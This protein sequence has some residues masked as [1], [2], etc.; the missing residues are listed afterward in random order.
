MEYKTKATVLIPTHN[1]GELIKFA[2]NSVLKQ[3]L[4]D[5][6]LIIIGDGAPEVTINI[7][8][9]YAAKDQR[10]QYFLFPKGERN[11]ELYRHQILQQYSRGEIVCYLSDDDIWLTTHLETMYAAL[12]EADMANTL[13]VK[14]D[15][16]GNLIAGVIDLAMPHYRK[17][18]LSTTEWGRF[19]LSNFAHRLDSY[20]KLPYGWRTTPK[21]IPTDLYMYQQFLNCKWV[22]AL[23]VKKITALHPPSSLRLH[24]S[25][26]ERI[27]ELSYWNDILD[28]TPVNNLFHDQVFVACIE[29]I[30][31][32]ERLFL[33]KPVRIIITTYRFMQKLMTIVQKNL[34]TYGDSA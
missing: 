3:T 5:F 27:N 4:Q 12:K 17:K 31:H 26:R 25:Q 10:I 30:I 29:R 18:L 24:Y 34:K 32:L 7:L 16:K 20:F 2:I 22:K 33:S 23:T 15:T 8:K 13:Q 1:H 9:D 21:G 6:E 28:S 14:D 19:G 11:G